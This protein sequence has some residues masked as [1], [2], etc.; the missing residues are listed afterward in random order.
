[1]ITAKT[2]AQKSY[3]PVPAGSHIARCY[4]MIEIGTVSYDWQGEKKHLHK[5]RITWELPLE[6]KVFDE[7]KGEQPFSI[8]KEYTLSMHEKANLRKDLEAWRGKAFTDDEARGFDITVLVGKPCMLNIVHATKDGNTYANVAGISP[9]PK[10]L[11][12]PKQVNTSFVLSY[13][14]F[15]FNKF[16]VLPQ[17]LKDKMMTTP[18][19]QAVSNPKPGDNVKILPNSEDLLF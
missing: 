5:V 16:D 12:C 10:G 13:D 19:F 4:S 6:T 3:E 7:A 11:E 17:F 2:S 15:D 1:M 14:A 8:S 18:E 9:M